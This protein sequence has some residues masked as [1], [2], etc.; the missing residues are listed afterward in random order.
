MSE[1][2]P[3]Q[4]RLSESERQ[5]LNYKS[6]GGGLSAGLKRVFQEAGFIGFE[7]KFIKSHQVFITR[8]TVANIPESYAYSLIKKVK[9]YV[10]PVKTILIEKKI[11]DFEKKID[12][13]SLRNILEGFFNV[14]L[15][16]PREVVIRD[17]ETSKLLWSNR[18]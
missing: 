13:Q 3:T 4:F 5:F 9:G 16:G 10:S 18:Q 7:E 6:N 12:N 17:S 1:L 8:S 2:I 14:S 15:S 11:L